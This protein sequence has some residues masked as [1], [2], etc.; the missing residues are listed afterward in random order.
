[1]GL[2]ELRRPSE[3]GTTAT[4]VEKVFF[5]RNSPGICL[6]DDFN[7]GARHAERFTSRSR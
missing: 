1:M 5:L 7:W 3:V 2:H 6:G 4:K